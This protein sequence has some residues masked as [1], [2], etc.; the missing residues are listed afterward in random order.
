MYIEVYV[1]MLFKN[2]RCSW[3]VLVYR[4]YIYYAVVHELTGGLYLLCWYVS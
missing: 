4:Q 2:V 1:F 3:T